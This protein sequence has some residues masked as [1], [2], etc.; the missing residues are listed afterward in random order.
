M[1]ISTLYRFYVYIISFIL[2]LSV[3]GGIPA[4]AAAIFDPSSVVFR[5]VMSGLTQ[6]IFI[7]NA[8]DGSN[9]LFIVERA[10][11]IWIFANGALVPAPFLD[12]RSI[13]NSSGAEQGLLSLA[14]HPN[15]EANGQF[16]TVY[17]DQNGSLILSR[18]VRSAA[19]SNIANPNSRTTILTI[20]HPTFQNHNGGT[21]AFGPYGYLY[22]SVGDGGSGGDP[23]NNA[24]NLNVL[25][26]K[27]L[28]LDVDHISP[29]L[30]YSI[31]GSNPFYNTLNRRGEIW[32]Y[33]L[34]N[35]WRFS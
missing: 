9:R 15:Y 22:W 4:A 20:S 31:P 23:S 5:E 10:G 8:G 11:R 35:P 18:F 29:G 14:F 32:A 26:G 13:V 6:P 28:R 25:L 7:A 12:I 3:I 30:N 33:G 16:Y 2:L 1:R 24:Q 21:L 27:I 34:R 19:D 17:T